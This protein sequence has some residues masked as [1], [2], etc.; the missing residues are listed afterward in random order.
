[1]KTKEGLKDR[2]VTLLIGNEILFDAAK[3]AVERLGYK[4]RTDIESCAHSDFAMIGSYF[5]WL[6]V[7]NQVRLINSSLPLVLMIVPP[8]ELNGNGKNFFG[9]IQLDGNS[10]TEARTKIEKWFT[11]GEGQILIKKG[12]RK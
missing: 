11:Q 7:V 5:L 8:Y 4:V 10:E 2:T 6:G 12:D 9:V 3:K 1:M